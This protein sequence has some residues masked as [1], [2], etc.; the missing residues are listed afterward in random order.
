MNKLF[1]KVAALSV[2]LAMAIGVGVAVGSKGVK[3]TKAA[4]SV[5][6]GSAVTINSKD[7]YKFGTSKVAGSAAITVDS[8]SNTLK[9]KAIGWKGETVALSISATGM[10]FDPSSIS[11]DSNDSITGTA[12][13]FTGIPETEY[14]VTYDAVSSST[15]ITVAASSGKRFI[16]WDVSCSAE[17]SG[18]DM[19]I[20]NNSYADGPFEVTYGDTAEYHYALG[21]DV[22]TDESLKSGVSWEVSDKSVIDYVVDGWT[23]LA[24]KPKAVGTTTITAS[25]DGYKSASTTITVVPG[26]LSSIAISGSMTKTA[27]KLN[28]S[29]SPAGLTVTATYDSGATADVTSSATWSYSPSTANSTSITSV[30]ATAS[31]GGKSASSSAQ[32]VTVVEGVTYDLSN[33]TGFSSWNSS[34]A[35]RT[36]TSSDVGSPVAATMNFKITNKQS[37]GVGSEYPCIGGKTTSEVEC[38]SFTLTQEGKKIS[39]IDI[40]FV[41]RYT[42]T[43]PS[44][45]LHKGSGISSEALSSLTMSGNQASEHKLSY[46]NL[47]DT[48]FTV[49]YNAHQTNSNGAVGIKEISIGLAD[50]SS[51]GTL[52]HI[53]VTSVPTTFVYHVGETYSDAGL[54][55]TAYDGPNEGTANFKDVTSEATYSFANGTVFTESHVPGFSVVVSYSTASN[56]TF[57]LAVY[58]L[59]DYEKVTSTPSDWSGQYLIVGTNADSELAA[60]NGALVNPDVEAG[61]KVVEAVDGVITSGQ[62][63]EWTIAAVSGGYSVQSKSGKYIGSLTA[64]SNGMLVSDSALVNTLSVADGEVTIAGTND[65]HLAFNTTGDRFRY[66]ASGT[67][68]LYKLKTSDKADEFAQTFLGAF[69][70]D[71]SGESEP[72]FGIKEGETHW[73]WS[74]LAEEYNKLSAAE[75]EQF[76]LGVPSQEGDNIARALA[77]Y[78]YIVGKYGT[79]K[80]ADFMSR[81]P[82]PIAS[83]RIND[84]STETNNNTMIIIVVIASISALAFTTLL[85]FKKK[86]QK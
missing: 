45:Y 57:P 26:T 39:S 4:A 14:T 18:K 7:G 36:V 68:Q 9:F 21:Y 80:Y 46:S 5:S 32:A 33:I 15:S 27:Y 16:L 41:T 28:D 66:Y 10:T 58:A 54:A 62:E 3:E 6:G 52:D 20:R 83:G 84:L 56:V 50:Q 31:Y 1:S 78:D 79:A 42:N 44:L 48:I 38:L 75:K 8:G 63:L 86:K 40:T 22:D 11:I 30:T 82:A 76:R 13:T 37:S 73:S 71:A 2:G 67:V 77:R 65:Y 49:G 70:C 24:Y 64:K 34:Y 69:T 23:W 43:Y 51:F 25:C 55:V 81:N 59:A 85:V 35:D 53:K 47:N 61:Y 29:W 72:S 74:L 19:G 60:M 17:G 12:T